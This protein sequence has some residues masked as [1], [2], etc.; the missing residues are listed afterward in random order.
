MCDSDLEVLKQNTLAY[1]KQLEEYGKPK[2]SY[3][4]CQK[5]LNIPWNDEIFSTHLPHPNYNLEFIKAQIN[6]DN[7]NK[8]IDCI[9]DNIK[10]DLETCKSDAVIVHCADIE[11]PKTDETIQNLE[12]SKRN[13]AENKKNIPELNVIP[14]VQNSIENLLQIKKLNLEENETNNFD[15]VSNYTENSKIKLMQKS[16][17]KWKTVITEKNNDYEKTENQ[18]HNKY[19]KKIDDFLQNIQKYQKSKSATNVE[20]LKTQEEEKKPKSSTNLDNKISS[21]QYRFKAQKNIIEMQKEKLQEQTKI[22][23]ELKL[24]KIYQQASVSLKEAE[25][26]KRSL[27]PQKVKQIKKKLIEENDIKKENE[28]IIE[29]PS[30]HFTKAPKIVM[31]MEERAKEREEKRL[32][33]KERRR[34]IEEEK[35]KQAELVLQKKIRDEIEERDKQKEKMRAQR[36][37]VRQLEI[38]R[39]LEKKRY[40]ELN[41]IAY[42]HY[43]IKLMKKNGMDHFKMLIFRIRIN[44]EIAKRFYENNLIMNCFKIWK[45][46]AKKEICSKN[47]L[48]DELYNSTILTIALGNWKTVR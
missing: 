47:E 33:I 19:Y 7:D 40:I 23:E 28:A 14:Q 2:I 22:I 15:V 16:V 48:A 13:E 24:N 39:Q 21:Y 27:S 12:E 35:K 29:N 26:T 38:K 11:K 46:F 42:R 18:P 31:Q 3:R 10:I 37:R 45:H 4:N 44:M 1:A 36:D 8:M 25:K 6:C 20:Q 17:N 5:N 41:E 30:L 43:R 34:L 9:D 32:I